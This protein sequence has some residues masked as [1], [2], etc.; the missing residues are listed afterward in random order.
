MEWLAEEARCFYVN[1]T[2]VRQAEEKEQMA[3]ARCTPG[4]ITLI[5]QNN[6]GSSP[7][8]KLVFCNI[9]SRR[10]R[11]WRT[12]KSN[13]TWQTPACRV[14]R[15]TVLSFLQ[16]GVFGDPKSCFCLHTAVERLSHPSAAPGRQCRGVSDTTAGPLV[17]ITTRKSRGTKRCVPEQLAAGGGPFCSSESCTKRKF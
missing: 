8:P 16:Q 13:Q 11:S 10:G 4:F 12:P 2:L 5:F 15:I 6:R 14:S 1:I 3:A 7:D 9:G 17:S